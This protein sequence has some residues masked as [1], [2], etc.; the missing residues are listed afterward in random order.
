[1]TSLAATKTDKT[2]T[3]KV[4]DG[5]TPEEKIV[6]ALVELMEKGE[7]PWRKEWNAEHGGHHINMITG[8]RYSGSNPFYLTMWA[9]LRGYS[10]PFW[11]GVAQAKAK[12]WYPKKG[13]KG[14]Y[15]LRPQLNKK[16][17]LDDAG[18]PALDAVGDPQIAA[19]V[20]YKAACVFN[21]ADL[22][23]EGLAEAIA[24]RQAEL[25]QLVRTD[26]ARQ[27]TAEQALGRWTVPVSYGHTGACYIPSEDRICLPD[28]QVFNNPD[29][30]YATWAHETIHSTGHKSR[31]NRDLSGRM[32]S[33]A[34]ARE[35]L[36]AELGAV[37][38]C[39]RLEIG[40]EFKNH[41]AYLKHWIELLKET[42]KLL[43]QVM[44]EARKGADLI[45]PPDGEQ[46]GAEE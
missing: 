5:P 11:L 3:K 21:V 41:A 43:F 30:F 28:L 29:G 34:Y 12:G 42:P 18:K 22:Q 14:C 40:S 25:G 33:K 32:D 9:A 16:E 13:S 38:L 24:A 23:G 19:W 17:L 8:H 7:T 4:Y 39:Q 37:L 27:A 36:V 10:M 2:R 20:S 1:M 6:S 26:H 46:A 35:E 44:S 31:L 15:I 45:C